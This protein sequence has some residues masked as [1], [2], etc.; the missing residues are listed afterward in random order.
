ME[1]MKSQAELLAEIY[2]LILNWPEQKAGPAA[3]NDK[4][5]L[6][7]ERE[8]KPRP[9]QILPDKISGEVGEK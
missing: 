6:L 9:I 1:N 3:D 5:R 2:R 4:D 7:T 8:R